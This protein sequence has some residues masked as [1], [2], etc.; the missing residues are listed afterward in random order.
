MNAKKLTEMFPK[1]R[2]DAM[3]SNLKIYGTQFG[4]IFNQLE[5]LSNSHLSLLAGEFARDYGKFHDYHEAIFKAYFT[6]GQD[7]G[8][9]EVIN[10]ILHELGLDIDKFISA[11]KEKLYEDRLDEASS[12]AQ[13]N[14]INS[15]PT[16][17]INNKY[18]VVGAQ[19]VESFRKALLDMQ[20]GGIL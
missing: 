18:A 8:K 1:D 4:L 17:I 20:K 12:A 14:Q 13:I 5:V 9:A 19:P 3:T 7:I 15:T 11:I 16:F 6:D 2:L 10:N